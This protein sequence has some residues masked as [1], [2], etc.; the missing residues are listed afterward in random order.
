MAI[1][2]IT[3][4][5]VVE[6]WRET[7]I[8]LQKEGKWFTL[9]VRALRLVEAISTDLMNQMMKVLASPKL[10]LVVYDEFEKIVSQCFV[11]FNTWEEDYDKV[12]S[13]KNIM[14]LIYIFW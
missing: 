5:D 13:K 4:L 3:W 12:N 10:T 7:L 1:Y 8:Q 6:K 9:Q 11:I 2:N 14:N